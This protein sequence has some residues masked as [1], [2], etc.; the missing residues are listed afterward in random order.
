MRARPHPLEEALHARVRLPATTL[1]PATASHYEYT[2]RCFMAYLRERFPDVRRPNQLR[3]DPHVLGWLEHLWTHRIR[4]SGRPLTATSRAAHLIR[5]R[6]LLELLA[7][8]A[9]P[10]RP[11]LLLS[12]DIPRPDQV[13]PRP[14]PPEE[15]AR[16]QAELRRRNDL[17]SNALLVTRLTGMRIG[18]TADLSADCLRPLGGD[19]WALHVPLGQLHTERWTSVDE[20]ARVL[21]TCLRFLRTLPPAAPQEFLLPRPKGRNALLAGLR[22][23][24]ADTARQAG[25]SAHVVPHQLRHYAAFRTMPRVAVPAAKVGH[26]SDGLAA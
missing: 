9:F 8:H 26:F 6:K 11:G 24:L 19:H 20:P 21:I 12:E 13:L 14:L 15:D 3:R 10:P 5:L 18:E 17:L 2:V 22:A 4:H 16:L 7:D 23:V 25:I 1:R